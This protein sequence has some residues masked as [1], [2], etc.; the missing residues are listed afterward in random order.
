LG[1]TNKGTVGVRADVPPAHDLSCL[2]ID[3]EKC[4]AAWTA[5]TPKLFL[6]IAVL[7]GLRTDEEIMVT[8]PVRIRIVTAS[9]NL[10]AHYP[11]E[12]FV[13]ASGAG[14]SARHAQQQGNDTESA[15]V[16]QSRTGGN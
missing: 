10:I 2:L 4:I 12:A 11:N 5:A 6:H 3:L 15:E 9:A 13:R 8:I 14:N 16:H 1:L 7:K